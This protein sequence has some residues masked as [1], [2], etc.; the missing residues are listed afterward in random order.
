M[1]PG[2]KMMLVSQARERNVGSRYEDNRESPQSYGRYE[3]TENRFRDRQGRERYDNGRFA[4]ERR[5]RTRSNDERY[6]SR[7]NPRSEYRSNMP[8]NER[9]YDVRNDDDDDDET[10]MEYGREKTS[11][12]IGFARYE[13]NGPQMNVG[14]RQRREKMRGHA[15][16]SSGRMD[17]EMAKEWTQGMQNADGTRGPHWTMDQAKTLMKQVGAMDLDPAE[18]WA[19]MNSLYS[20]YCTVMK[21]YGIDRTEIYANLAK[22]WIEDDDAVPDKAAAYFEYVVEK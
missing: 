19:V 21:K 8:R 18:F 22:A 13:P 6:E 16:G 4:P 3:E 1:K 9:R 14:E 20:D 10:E 11:N 12:I 17:H 7:S 15:S 2:M 5:S